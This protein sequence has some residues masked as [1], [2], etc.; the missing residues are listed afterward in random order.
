MKQN[1]KRAVIIAGASGMLLGGGIAIAIPISASGATNSRLTVTTVTAK[2][3]AYEYG[4]TNNPAAT[5][6]CPAGTVLTGGGIKLP[7]LGN[8]QAILESHPNTKGNGWVGSYIAG[9]N[10]EIATVY[11][12]CVSISG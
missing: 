10:G 7:N 11:A 4:L 1:V 3:P 9:Q 8:L 6:V 2:T 5:A 12:R